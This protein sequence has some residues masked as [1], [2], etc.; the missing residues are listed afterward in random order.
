MISPYA[1]LLI[2]SL[3]LGFIFI[4]FNLRRKNFPRNILGYMTMLNIAFTLYF[5]ELLSI[6]TSNNFLSFSEEFYIPGP[7]SLGGAIGLLLAMII[8]TKIYK[9]NKQDIYNT[10]ALAVPLMYGISKLG[11]HLVGCCYGI[12]YNGFLA[13]SSIFEEKYDKLFP[14]QLLESVIFILIF[15][16]SI[17]IYTRRIQINYIAIEMIICAISKFVLDYLRYS[18]IDVVLSIN[19]IICLIFMCIGALII[20][21]QH[22]RIISSK[23]D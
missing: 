23:G 9:N 13:T 11:C 3:I 22:K 7:S 6:I 17:I 19:Q 16:I 5:G 8:F 14:I 10:Y 1:I 12:P 20:I 21:K 2:T 18:H 15:I 4:Y